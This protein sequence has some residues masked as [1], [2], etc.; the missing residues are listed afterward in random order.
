MVKNA[1]FRQKIENWVKII[2]IPKIEILDKK[3][4]IT[5]NFYIKICKREFGIELILFYTVNIGASGTV[6]DYKYTLL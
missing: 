4:N 5:A 6:S 2:R 1:N 3:S